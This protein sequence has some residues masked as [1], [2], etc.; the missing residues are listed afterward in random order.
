MSLKKGL[1]YCTINMQ[2]KQKF[3]KTQQPEAS[4]VGMELEQ[5]LTLSRNVPQ[6]VMDQV[7]DQVVKSSR[8]YAV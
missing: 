2:E 5:N 8:R 3:N 1:T 7:M 6:Q 4:V